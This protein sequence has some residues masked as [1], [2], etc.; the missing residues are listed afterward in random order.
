M[1]RALYILI[2][3]CS[4]SCAT[5]RQKEQ[6]GPPGLYYGK[7]V[8]L[9]GRGLQGAVVS[10]YAIHRLDYG[11]TVYGEVVTDDHGNFR[12]ST[13]GEPTVIQAMYHGR[14]GVIKDPKTATFIK[15]K[16]EE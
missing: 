5:Y 8:E 1:K 16:I 15:I 4:S 2:L 7:V 6:K 12:F 11:I 10:A 14:Q 13:K 3:I 9:K